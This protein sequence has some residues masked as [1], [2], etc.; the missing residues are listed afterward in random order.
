MLSGGM[1]RCIRCN[2]DLC[3]KGLAE[4]SPELQI[5]SEDDAP[6]RDLQGMSGARVGVPLR[7][8]FEDNVAVALTISG[9]KPSARARL[10]A[11]PPGGSPRPLRQ[12]LFILTRARTLTH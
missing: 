4:G 11:P 12:F 1:W 6:C 10:R 9:A 7:L 8:P 3:D 5:G 2:E